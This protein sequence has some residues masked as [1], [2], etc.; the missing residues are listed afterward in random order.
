MIKRI[1]CRVVR[2]EP[3]VKSINALQHASRSNHSHH[4]IGEAN[5]HYKST[6]D[7]FIYTR[8]LEITSISIKNSLAGQI[9]DCY[10]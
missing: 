10:V 9:L 5:F 3:V 1:S 8:I 6:N 7:T 2:T 4:K